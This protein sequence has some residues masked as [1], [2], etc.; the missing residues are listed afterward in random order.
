MI[1]KYTHR[2]VEKT[3]IHHRLP[4]I[5]HGNEKSKIPTDERYCHSSVHCLEGRREFKMNE[6]P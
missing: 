2:F 1:I 5:A 6:M 3:H 4:L